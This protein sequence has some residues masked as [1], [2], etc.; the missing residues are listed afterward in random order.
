[1][2]IISFEG[3]E[4]VGKSTQRSMLDSDIVSKGVATEV[5]KEPG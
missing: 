4:V 1:M 2:K 5:L 3:V